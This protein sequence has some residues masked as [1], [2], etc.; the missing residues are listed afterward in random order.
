MDIE[1]IVCTAIHTAAV[2]AFY[3]VPSDRPSAFVDVMQ[4]GG[5]SDMF[6]TGRRQVL[7]RCWA[8]TRAQAV[9]IKDTAKSSVFSLIK[10]DEV[11][12]VSIASEY[13]DRDIDS[14]TPRACF[15]ADIKIN[16]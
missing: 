14:G 6:G 16:I 3:D 15:L 1:L 8:Q 2:P 5:D 12:S 10:N 7:V 4:T 9:Q 13:R 11:L